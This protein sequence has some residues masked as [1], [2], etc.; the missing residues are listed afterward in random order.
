[1]G[2]FEMGQPVIVHRSGLRY[3]AIIAK[4]GRKLLTIEWDDHGHAASA[5]F[6]MEDQK[7]NL[8][9][10]RTYSSSGSF[11]TLEQDARAQRKH[12]AEDGFARLGLSKNRHGSL[13]LPEME[14]VIKLLDEM[15]ETS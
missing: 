4:V 13:T 11:R 8:P 10:S 15:R 2:T 7:E 14:A 12:A 3:E 6:R 9:P 5:Q 1:M